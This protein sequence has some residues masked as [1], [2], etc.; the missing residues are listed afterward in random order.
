[1]HVG[2]S[3]TLAFALMTTVARTAP[4]TLT[5]AVL[6]WRADGSKPSGFGRKKSCS[7]G[8]PPRCPDGYTGCSAQ[9][10]C[11]CSPGVS[12]DECDISADGCASYPCKHG[13]TCIDGAFSYECVC[14]DGYTSACKDLVADMREVSSQI[15]SSL[16]CKQAAGWP[17]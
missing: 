11:K 2:T 15:R 5:S 6:P 12:G 13:A 4:R 17:R 16:A 3:G 10:E 7:N 8:S 1:M 9:H 14:L